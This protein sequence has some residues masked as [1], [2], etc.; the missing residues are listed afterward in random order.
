M[1]TIKNFKD[2]LTFDKL[3]LKHWEEFNTKLPKFNKQY[4]S[5]LKAV[6]FEENKETKG[7]VFF[8]IYPSPYYDELWGQIDMFYLSPEYRNKG[9]GKQMF[10]MVEQFLK[11]AG[12]KNI[13]ASYNLKLPLESFYSSLGYMPTHSVMAKEI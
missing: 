7:Y 2:I 9:I 1:I 13:I 3:S 8:G 10:I 12:C 11:E 4:L 5:T 6:V